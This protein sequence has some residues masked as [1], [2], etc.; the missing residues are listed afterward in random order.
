LGLSA[1]LQIV[2]SKL[3]LA[4]ATHL[5]GSP[6]KAG[7][8]SRILQLLERHE[9]WLAIREAL[10]K[11]ADHLGE[12]GAPINYRRRRHI[13]YTTLLP[14]YVWAQMCRDTGSPGGT[15]VRARVA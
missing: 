13:D 4:E 15:A 8:V 2:G 5:I 3:T 6:L 12:H 9:H 14:N 11:M 1:A 10:M 7:A